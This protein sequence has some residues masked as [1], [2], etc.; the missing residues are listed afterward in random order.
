MDLEMFPPAHDVA[1]RPFA[2]DAR[3][4][5]R[6]SFF[7]GGYVIAVVYPAYELLRWWWMEEFS[8]FSGSSLLVALTS[9]ILF[10]LFSRGVMW[11]YLRVRPSP[12]GTDIPGGGGTHAVEAADKE[13]P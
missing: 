7:L 4:V 2:A 13:Q 5:D 3:T 8:P 12:A 6:L 1:R 10:G 9:G 11:R